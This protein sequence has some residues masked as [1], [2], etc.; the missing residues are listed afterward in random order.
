MTVPVP[1]HYAHF[2]EGCGT[3]AADSLM[4]ARACKETNP[5]GEYISMYPSS[6]E[7]GVSIANRL[8]NRHSRAKASI[9]GEIFGLMFVCGQREFR[10]DKLLFGRD[11]K[12]GHVNSWCLEKLNELRGLGCNE[13]LLTSVY[14]SFWD[15][16]EGKAYRDS[17][18][19]SETKHL[20]VADWIRLRTG[21]AG[22]F[23]TLCLAI[24]DIEHAEL[25]L[26]TT[27]DKMVVFIDDVNDIVSIEKDQ[28]CGV[29]NSLSHTE[30]PQSRPLGAIAELF[31]LINR[32]DPETVGKI[33][34]FMMDYIS[35]HLES[36]RYLDM[37]SQ[38]R[39]T[40]ESWVA[41]I[42]SYLASYG[43]NQGD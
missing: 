4:I 17:V 42:A 9:A 23:Y 15:R 6:F 1:Q 24:L 12:L 32:F 28:R 7:E 21:F 35:W 38:F 33:A 8:L 10:I 27:Y 22:P 2:D 3:Q 39:R 29:L 13:K 14:L 37:G 5:M 16:S 25:V 31:R 36:E 18:A 19:L 20:E 26:A 34:I 40:C 41:L 30:S 11:E 43:S